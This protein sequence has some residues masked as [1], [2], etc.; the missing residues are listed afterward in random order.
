M[1]GL[2]KMKDEIRKI[3]LNG[4]HEVYDYGSG[5]FPI[6]ALANLKFHNDT[7]SC[8]IAGKKYHFTL[9]DYK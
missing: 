2:Y 1:N 9:K 7:Y 3:V 5:M 8:V 4:R 6:L